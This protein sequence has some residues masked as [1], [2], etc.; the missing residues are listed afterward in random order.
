MD[1]RVIGLEHVEEL[2]R[3]SIT[4]CQKIPF[5]KNLLATGNLRFIRV[6]SPLPV[7]HR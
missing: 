4:N 7:N 3:Q 2:M 1:D 6:R 5:L